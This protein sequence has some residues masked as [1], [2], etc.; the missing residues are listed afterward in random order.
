MK[1]DI[2]HAIQLNLT[3][4]F[5]LFLRMS[6]NAQITIS[7]E[8]FPS[9]VGTF[10]ITEGDTVDSVEVNVGF[11]GENQVW[12]FDKEFPG[13]HARQLI[14]NASD[15]NYSQYFPEANLVSQYIGS[16]G[17]LIHSYYF[18]NTKGVFHFFQQKTADRILIQGIGID[19]AA[20]N[21]SIFGFKF[22]GYIEIKPAIVLYNCP[23]Q[24]NDIWE[25]AS[26]FSIQ[27]DTLL[28][29]NRITL[30][31]LVQDSIYNVVDGWGKIILPSSRF[32]CLRLKSYITLT[33]KLFI[34]GEEFRSRTTRTI[35]Y[36]WITK[37][38]GIVAKI[39]SHSDQPDDN[40]QYA[41]QVC[42]LHR[43]NPQID[44]ALADTSGKPEE[45]VDI[46]VYVSGLTDLNIRKIRM[47]VD[48][49]A[50][51]IKALQVLQS[52]TLIEDWDDLYYGVINNKFIVALGGKIPLEEDG[53]LFY[54]RVSVLPTATP[55]TTEIS[56]C[57]FVVDEPGPTVVSH[58]GHFITSSPTG[59]SE[60]GVES[61]KLPGG[62]KLYSNYPNP[63]N[64]NTWISYQIEQTSNVRLEIV[65]SLG[66]RI[67]TL[68]NQ[69]Q[70]S[71]IYRI[72][73][74]G[75]NSENQQLTSG[76]YF[77]HLFITPTRDRH[78]SFNFCQKMIL[79]R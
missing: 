76:V 40:F 45:I 25:S 23:I 10:M 72:R 48:Y 12:T 61:S 8:D 33:E 37:E 66:R 53:I 78:N 75:T 24:I 27:V 50:N 3:L 60:K 6:L 70:E 14:V 2:L 11:P 42:R 77:C 29:G 26:E 36:S 7:V 47:Q 9:N 67:C 39:T 59:L 73:W 30:S 51:L 79:L 68:V 69:R 4:L 58:A 52:N 74:P 20:V 31:A 18:D 5:V 44:I 63:F 21:F 54:L 64:A 15:A 56:L 62:F 1:N 49:D 46:P 35:N 32:D 71:G 55:D 28:F 41:K 43:F 38:Y 17:N 57:D 22:S 65:N 34:N 16:L 19:S 13:E